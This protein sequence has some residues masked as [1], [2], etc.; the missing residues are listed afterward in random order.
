MLHMELL[1]FLY[2]LRRYLMSEAEPGQD[3]AQKRL[4]T[5]GC[6]VVHFVA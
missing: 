6:E 2:A 3:Q 1:S 4:T 5:K